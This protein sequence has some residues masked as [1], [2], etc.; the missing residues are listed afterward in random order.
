MIGFAFPIHARCNQSCNISL[1]ST[2]IQDAHTQINQI[3]AADGKQLL[4]LCMQEK[5]ALKK[6]EFYLAGSW[7]FSFNYRNCTIFINIRLNISSDDCSKHTILAKKL[8]L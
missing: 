3:T 2:I 8:Y 7:F 5:I 1:L 6:R 4:G